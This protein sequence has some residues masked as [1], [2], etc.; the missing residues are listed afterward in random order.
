MIFIARNVLATFKIM[1]ESPDV[2][3]T[4]LK[5]EIKNLKIGEIKDIK[6][7]PIGFGLKAMKILILV[8]DEGGLIEEIE[9]QLS[10]LKGV[11][12]A[13]NEGVTLI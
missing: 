4:R 2:D 9:Q 13:E 8:P 11:R 7:E 6:E 12:T 10:K 5:S 3:L 1:P